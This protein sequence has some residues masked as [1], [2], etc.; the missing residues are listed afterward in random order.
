MISTPSRRGFT[1][2]ELLVVIA[3]IAILAAML[4]PVLSNAKQKAQQTFC[5][6]NI[7]QLHMAFA[8]YQD[9]Y[10]SVGIEYNSVISGT[11]Q[12]TLW[13]AQMS[14]YYAQVNQCRLCPS[15][16]V[17]GIGGNWPTNGGGNATAAWHW[18]GASNPAYPGTLDGSY[19]FNGA[20]YAD[21]PWPTLAFGR[22]TSIMGPT[23]VP[24]FCDGAWCDYGMD[25][26]RGPTPGLN[27][28]TLAQSYPSGAAG[29]VPAQ[30]PDR[31]LVSRHPLKGATA[32]FRQQ[33]PGAIN[34][35]FVDGHATLF[36]FRDWG[37][38]NWYQGY[39]P[40]PG[41]IAPW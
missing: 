32:T 9:D 19:A 36:N 39:A 35:V 25:V 13:M 28:L 15:A 18:F 6:N 11:L 34:M 26:S 5:L 29:Q 41:I 24:L 31:I 37:N 14:P 38:L 20:L 12:G 17:G 7:K 1:L 27:M 23:T 40:T 16:P 10:N 21:G 2:I 3:I 30:P 33:I 4:L 8:L 22:V